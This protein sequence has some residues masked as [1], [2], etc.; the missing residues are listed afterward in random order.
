[1]DPEINFVTISMVYLYNPFNNQAPRLLQ[2]IYGTDVPVY[3]I[4][5]PIIQIF[6]KNL[7]P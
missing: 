2:G 6:G 5:I 3:T 1:M 4:D 7:F